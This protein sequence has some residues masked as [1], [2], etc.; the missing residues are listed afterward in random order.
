MVHDSGGSIV[1]FIVLYVQVGKFFPVLLFIASPDKL[2][3]VETGGEKFDVLH[4]LLRAVS[5]I[6]NS[7][8]CEDAHVCTF[9]TK[10]TL[11]E[12][13]K[14]IEASSILVVF[15]HFF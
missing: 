7:Q 1:K 5:S 12:S 4:K 11:H 3:N 15:T 13:N 6:Q 8:F 10:T 14:F 9:K 2:R